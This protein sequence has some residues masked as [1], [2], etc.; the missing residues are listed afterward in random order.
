VTIVWRVVSL[1]AALGTALCAALSAALDVSLYTDI[2]GWRLEVDCDRLMVRGS[3]YWRW[4]KSC[5]CAQEGVL[6]RS[7]VPCFYSRFLRVGRID[8][9][10]PGTALWLCFFLVSFDNQDPPLAPVMGKSHMPCFFFTASG[11]MPL[12]PQLRCSRSEAILC[13]SSHMPCFFFTAPEACSLGHA[14]F[15]QH[16]E[17][18]PSGLSRGAPHQKRDAMLLSDIT[19]SMPLEPQP[20]CSQPE[21]RRCKNLTWPCFFFTASGSMPLGPQLRCSRSEAIHCQNSRMPCF[22]SQ[23]LIRSSLPRIGMR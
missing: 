17:A 3:L 11:S 13:Q 2:V 12:G 19:R 14:S 8:G 20:R 21:A 18:C 9:Q 22:F 5:E 4:I 7:K 15:S 1:D 10:G 6:P 23:H 16:R